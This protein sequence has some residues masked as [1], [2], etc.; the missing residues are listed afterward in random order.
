MKSIAS[1]ISLL[2]AG[3]VLLVAAGLM[4][5]NRLE[6]CGQPTTRQSTAEAVSLASLHSPTPAPP[7]EVVLLKLETDKPDLEIVG[8]LQD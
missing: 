5:S 7:Q 2:L 1:H 4:C 8:W 6:Y 3:V